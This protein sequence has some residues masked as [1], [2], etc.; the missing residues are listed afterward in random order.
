MSIRRQLANTCLVV[1]FMLAGALLAVLSGLEGERE[2]CRCQFNGQVEYVAKCNVEPEKDWSHLPCN[3][4][5]GVTFNQH[6]PL[7]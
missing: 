3:F 1:A 7:N 5:P 2:E 4:Q 6:S